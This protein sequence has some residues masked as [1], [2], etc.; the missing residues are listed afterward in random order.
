MSARPGYTLI[1]IVVVCALLAIA[2]AV[3]VPE[4]ASSH[5]R[6]SVPAAAVRFTLVLREAQA[7]ASALG[8]PVR[9]SLTG[10]GDGY[11]V[12]SHAGDRLV[13]S[14]SFTG[15]GCQTNYPGA[16]VEFAPSGFPHGVDGGTRAGTFT[17]AAGGVTS[18]VVVQMG[19]AVRCR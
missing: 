14:G 18:S 11:V 16:T 3:C 12:S 2:A 4:L 1:E 17:F 9:V 5:G 6:A 8:A 7:R 15:A 10:S 19:G 13:A